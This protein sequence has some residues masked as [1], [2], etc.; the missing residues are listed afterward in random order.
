MLGQYYDVKK[1]M[2]P[3]LQHSNENSNEFVKRAH[4][5]LFYC[6]MKVLTV[7]KISTVRSCF[8]FIKLVP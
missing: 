6:I 1:N 3:F 2:P 4:F 5:A 7:K 8:L